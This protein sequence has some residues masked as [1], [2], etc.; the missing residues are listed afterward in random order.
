MVS[1][2]LPTRRYTWLDA[3]KFPTQLSLRVFAMAGMMS[4]PDEEENAF[5]SPGAHHRRSKA[6][7]QTMQSNINGGFALVQ[8]RPAL[9]T[10]R[11]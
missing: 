9:R 7:I 11:T 6:L 3:K 4:W 10:R 1:V 2:K 8:Q 5:P